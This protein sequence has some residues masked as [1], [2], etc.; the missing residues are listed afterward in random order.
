MKTSQD[1]FEF[2]GFSRSNII[3]IIIIMEFN[4]FLY[5]LCAESTATRPITDTAV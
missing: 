5:D 2:A 4:S 3:L 1:A